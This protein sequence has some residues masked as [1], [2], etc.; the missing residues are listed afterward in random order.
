MGVST[1]NK[2]RHVDM[3]SAS[4]LFARIYYYAKKNRKRQSLR[5]LTVTIRNRHGSMQ[6][7]KSGALHLLKH[8]ENAF[9]RAHE[10][11]LVGLSKAATLERIA[12]CT[13]DFFHEKPR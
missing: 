6:H 1:V 5:L 3:V 7:A 10:Q 9:G 12:A 2:C 11:T 4:S 13:I 8:L